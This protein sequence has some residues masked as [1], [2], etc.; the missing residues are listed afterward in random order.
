M[1]VP[2]IN[3]AMLASAVKRDI[4]ERACEIDKPSLHEDS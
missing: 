4:D 2:P 3:A 1:C